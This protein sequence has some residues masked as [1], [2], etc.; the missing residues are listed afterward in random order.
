MKKQKQVRQ[1]LFISTIL[2]YISF[3]V[4]IFSGAILYEIPSNPLHLFLFTLGFLSPFIASLI[5]YLLNKDE[6]GGLSAFADNFKIKIS[7]KALLVLIGLVIAHYAFG[8]ILD[9]IGSYGNFIDFLKF[10]PV[11][12][13]LLG[14]Q[15]IG[16]RKII[17]PYYEE[18]KGFYRSVIITGLFWSIWFLP[19]LFIRGFFVLPIF[20]TQFATYLIGI[21]FL[22]TSIYKI[23]KQVSYSMVL[24]SLIFALAPVI[25][26]KQGWLLLAIGVLEVFIAMILRN[27]KINT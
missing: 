18:K 23:T 4:L 5:L 10:L 21:S 9:N 13:I 20:Y 26:F 11:M 14:S 2:S 25:L 1:F 16:W 24:S 3:G 22:L 27:K 8:I 17:Q 7:K 19:L 6:L 12:A 15:E